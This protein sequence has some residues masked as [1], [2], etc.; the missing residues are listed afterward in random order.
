MSLPYS[1][2]V[3]VFLPYVSSFEVVSAFMC[4][5]KWMNDNVYAIANISD[6]LN[7]IDIWEKHFPLMKLGYLKTN[8]D[9]VVAAV[10]RV[11]H[12][13][14]E[15]AWS[16][17][18]YDLGHITAN[19]LTLVG[20][21]IDLWTL[22]QIEHLTL[23][24]NYSETDDFGHL[25]SLKSLHLCVTDISEDLKKFTSVTSLHI[26]RCDINAAIVPYIPS[27]R[28]LR[29][30]DYFINNLSAMTNL[31]ELDARVTDDAIAKLT[32]LT[33]LTIHYPDKV[34]AQTLQSLPLLRTV[35]NVGDMSE[36]EVRPDMSELLDSMAKKI[37]CWQLE[38]G[39]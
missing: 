36:D 23:C 14:I 31:T 32:S 2:T 30:P 15:Y 29:A 12:L 10:R 22:P 34:L 20:T 16:Y 1:I 11:G 37:A 25:T 35:I 7:E 33:S 26:D 21:N 5:C 24:D 17:A 8:S 4:T 9:L 13:H 28:V 3:D 18:V 6:E 27:L 38:I 39:I 19:T